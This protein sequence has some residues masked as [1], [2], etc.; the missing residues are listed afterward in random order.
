MDELTVKA[1]NLDNHTSQIIQDLYR[2]DTNDMSNFYDKAKFIHSKD[3]TDL[4][5][6]CVLY[7][8]E[9]REYDH[10]YERIYSPHYIDC[11]IVM[12]KMSKDYVYEPNYTREILT[13]IS[14]KMLMEKLDVALYQW[15]TFN[16]TL[17]QLLSRSE[18]LEKELI[19]NWLKMVLY[20]ATPQ[21]AF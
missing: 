14:C 7:V 21:N 1:Q 17:V 15:R 13:F 5:D 4:I 12:G 20:A 10:T 18:V 16:P 6:G 3:A 8:E 19:S 2:L 9:I 11:G